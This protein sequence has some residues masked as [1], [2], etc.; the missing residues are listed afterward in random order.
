MRAPIS[1]IIPT[2]NATNSLPQTVA[3]LFEG[4][5]AGLIREL[6]FS[7]GGSDDQISALAEELGA[8]LITGDK[9]RGGQLRRGAQNASA[10]WFLFLHAD[11]YLA[12][13]WSSKVLDH[14]TA[15]PD[16]AACFRLRFR[17]SGLRPVI[18]ASWANLRSRL[19]GLPY[20][21]Q[22][23]LISQRLYND[24]GGYQDIP[25]M[26]DVAIARA[27]RGNI[28]LLNSAASTNADKFIRDGW[29]WRGARNLW[30]LSRYFAG[31]SPE[32]LASKYDK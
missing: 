7:D 32:S 12:E 29:F 16:Q 5:E 3:S 28:R 19:L 2:L 25:L 23:L 8:S 1:V 22:G 26:E 24:L 27:L 9:S 6:I 31:A 4:L 18:V 17:H 15:H 13:N 20:G 21:D 14:I 11:T 30:A 10:G